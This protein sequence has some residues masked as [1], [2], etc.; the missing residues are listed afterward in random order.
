LRRAPLF[1]LS[2]LVLLPGAA[3]A[4]NTF[5]VLCYHDVQEDVRTVADPYALDTA[6][7]VSQ[8]AWLREN[9]FHVIGLDDVLAAREGRHALPDKALLLSFDDGY[10]SV[11]TRVFPLLKA[12]NYPA[13]VALSGRWLDVPETGTVEYE[14]RQVARSRFLSWEQ[15]AEMSATGLVEI[16]SHSYDLHRGIPANPQNDM[17]PALVAYRIDNGVYEDE[18][19][20]AARVRADFARNADLIKSRT[21]RAPRIMVWPYGRDSAQAIEIARDFGMPFAMNLDGGGNDVAGD[22]ARIRRDVVINNPSLNDFIALVEREPQRL[23][24]R[25]LQVDLDYIY[26]ADPRQQQ[27]NIGRLLDRVRALRVTTVY[28]QA[29]ADPDGN[30]QAD[31]TY[32][33]N[34][35]LPMRAD[36]FSHVAW[37]L[38]TRSLVNVYAWMPVLAYELPSTHPAAQLKVR[39][40]DPAAPASGGRYRRL[41]PFSA[42]VRETIGEIYEDL[43]RHA[44]IDGLLFHDDATLD[45]FEDASPAARETYA[46]WGLPASLEAIHADPQLF[47][48]WSSRKTAALVSFTAELAQRVRRYQG[49]IRTARNLYAAPVL[50]SSAEARF[51]QSLPAFLAAYDYAALMAMP[52][53]EGAQHPDA[54][55][56]A[57]ARK[58]AAVQDGLPRTL[59]ELQ[60]VDWNTHKPVPAQVLAAQLQQLQRLGAINLGY[61]PDDFATDQP[62]LMRIK[63]AISLQNFPRGD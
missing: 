35:H 27:A 36:L 62:A 63:P 50:D 16:A 57:L 13:V 12:F 53:L 30:G 52:M 56:G 3:L 58:V 25:V 49:T 45:E 40:I 4:A 55:F 32:F 33:P 5:R 61:Y 21:G 44:R 7:L 28:L 43:A 1:V 23:P 19:A 17:I 37:Q 48:A 31:A 46:A 41:T 11:Y 51:A 8:F 38:H 15:V 39:S 18:R 24:Q 59:F 60:S 42:Q 47:N 9:G 54:W 29:F 34:R 6:Q 10:R 26:D 22:L 20:H 2:L 14:G